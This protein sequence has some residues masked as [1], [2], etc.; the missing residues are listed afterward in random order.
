[1]KDLH[2]IK[3]SNIDALFLHFLNTQFLPYYEGYTGN[4]GMFYHKQIELLLTVC[5]H[6]SHKVTIASSFYFS[7]N[8]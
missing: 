1:M 2:K 5:K 6:T 7:F 4:K 3:E 8:H